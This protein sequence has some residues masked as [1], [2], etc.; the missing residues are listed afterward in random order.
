MSQGA[1]AE[2]LIYGFWRVNSGTVGDVVG[3]ADGDTL[4][5]AFGSGKGMFSIVLV[6]RLLGFGEFVVS[7]EFVGVV[8]FTG[9]A[10]LLLAGKEPPARKC[11]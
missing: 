4:G 5:N 2:N 6:P 9:L 7:V 11:S 3:E 8:E 1:I 10:E